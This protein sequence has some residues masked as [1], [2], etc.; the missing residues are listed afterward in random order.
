MKFWTLE[1]R[2]AWNFSSLKASWRDR[3]NALA[4]GYALGD[5]ERYPEQ[6]S[7]LGYRDFDAKAMHRALSLCSYSAISGSELF[8]SFTSSNVST[9]LSSTIFRSTSKVTT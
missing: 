6:A 3:S 2:E 9:G 1:E 5:A 4:R 8:I 7:G